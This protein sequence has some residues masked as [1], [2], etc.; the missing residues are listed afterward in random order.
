MKSFSHASNASLDTTTSHD[1]TCVAMLARALTSLVLQSARESRVEAK[2]LARACTALTIHPRLGK[3]ELPLLS[4]LS[5]HQSDG[6]GN[7]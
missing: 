6:P 5:E 7:Y 3:C 1:H 4:V 2:G